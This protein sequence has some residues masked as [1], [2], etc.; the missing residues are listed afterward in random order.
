MD[1]STGKN[2]RWKDTSAL[3]SVGF[4][5]TWRQKS[6]KYQPQEALYSFQAP[7][8]ACQFLDDRSDSDDGDDS[9]DSDWIQPKKKVLRRELWRIYS[10]K[11][12]SYLIFVNFL[13]SMLI[14]FIAINNS[15]NIIKFGKLSWDN[16]RIRGKL[17][18]MTN[19][20]MLVAVSNRR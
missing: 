10:F 6:H 18:W 11:I 5:T 2:N 14:V 1:V 15:L 13:Q 7:N 3:V 4:A 12:T 9:D 16:K 19:P 8:M 20:M 17:C